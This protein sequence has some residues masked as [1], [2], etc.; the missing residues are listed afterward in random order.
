MDKE[1]KRKIQERNLD[2]LAKNGAFQ[3]TPTF[4]PYTSGEIG[5]YY[6]Q[7]AAILKNG[8]DYCQACEDMKDLL[9]WNLNAG[10]VDVISGGES[11]DWIFSFPLAAQ[12]GLPHAMLYK[13][14]KSLGA[15]MSGRKVVHVADLNNEGSSPRDKWV[16]AIQEAGG[17]IDH[18]LF[19]VDRLEDGVQ[20][21]KDLG[22][23]S[24]SVVPLDEHAWEY[25]Q[26]NGVV[27]PEVY[28]QLTSR[29]K[30]KD[31]W[32]Q[33]MLRS[34]EGRKT[35]ASLFGEPKTNAKA[36]NILD[37]GYS[38]MRDELLESMENYGIS[39]SVLGI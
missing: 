39:R 35:L 32:A 37:N 20:T 2:A 30:D 18:I 19:Y 29:A 16:P 22:L 6:V 23:Q 38:E 36:R 11:R 12:M 5:P 17:E 1:R 27:S 8:R 21:M 15:D 10:T 3:F 14:G 9:T 7:S 4:F 13:N 25:L 33:D 34:D 26:K 31:A 24:H 28:R